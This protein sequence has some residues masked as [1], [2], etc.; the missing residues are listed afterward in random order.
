MKTIGILGGLGPQATM[1]FEAR[2]HAVAQQIIPQQGNSGHPPLIVYYH[3]RPP[4]VMQDERTPVFPLQPDPDLLQAAQWLGTRADFL[5]ITAN[6]PHILQAQIEQA[7]GHKVLGMIEITLAEVQRRGWH[8]IG[9]LGFGP[10]DVPVYTQPL[11]QLNLASEIITP[12][13][14]GPLNVAVMRMQEGR[15]NV[16]DTQAVREA[17]A[18]LRARQVDGIIPGCTELPLL[19]GTDADVPDLINPAQLLAE[20][21]VRFALV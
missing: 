3:R 14:Q 18:Y 4:F 19:L 9:V 20:A 10:P 13:L 7:S 15:A 21:A 17:V 11:S 1:D 6:G 5:V 2:L 8:T 12:E 16:E